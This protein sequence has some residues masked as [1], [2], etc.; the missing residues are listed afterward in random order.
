MSRL[1]YALIAT[2]MILAGAI[3]ADA[4]L[5]APAWLSDQ[6][7][8]PAPPCTVF[9]PISGTLSFCSASA[10]LPVSGG[11]TGLGTSTGTSTTGFG[12]NWYPST[13]TGT[14][15][16]GQQMMAVFVDDLTVAFF[17]RDTGCANCL[18]VA[19][20]S[21][22]GVSGSFFSTAAILGNSIS[23]AHRVPTSP[24]RYLVSSQGGPL[25]IFQSVS[26]SGGWVAVTGLA[27][28][29]AA[30]ASNATGTVV[31][32][33]AAPAAIEVCK[34]VD[35]GVSFS[36]CV[37]VG[38]V[39]TGTVSNMGIAF[40]GGTTWL[41][42]NN[43]GQIFR[44]IND[45]AAWSL[46]A[47]LGGNGRAIRCLATGYTTCLYTANDGNIYRSTDS[48]STWTAVQNG[49]G[50]TTGLC[51]Y[52]G[53]ISATMSG[54]PPS[55]FAAIALNTFA[56]FTSGLGWF[57]GQTNGS[58]WDGTGVPALRTL[59]CRNGRGI[60]TYSTTGGGTNVFAVYNPLTQPGGVL[61]SSAGGYSIAAPIQA[62]I[63]LNA[64]PV[65]SAANTAA[66]VTL[67]GTAGSRICIRSIT[68]FSSAAGAST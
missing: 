17:R 56:S 49:V 23:A 16:S 3:T 9:D 7:G 5:R 55:G 66:A 19:L 68:L 47:T 51:D 61:Q 53:G 46:V 36:G 37:T 34:S 21:D 30:W 33:Y 39:T 48:G 44:S 57:A 14:V 15:A 54:T 18:Q 25:N 42:H 26:L 35:G 62:G 43:S 45:G 8:Q 28:A 31:L 22:G 59:D 1:Y 41:L 4:Q 64:A 2:L 12:K 52:G 38:A 67:T 20:S 13:I 65:T 50:V 29:I 60:A 6:I 32:S 58:H 63:I 11:G 40:A 27:N 10:P 24:P